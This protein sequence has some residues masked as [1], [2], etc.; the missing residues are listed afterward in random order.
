MFDP[1]VFKVDGYWQAIHVYAL[2]S[3]WIC[4]LKAVY[5]RAKQIRIQ[6]FRRL[7]RTYTEHY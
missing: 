4:N 6:E 7:T 2:V 1:F 3:K 5:H